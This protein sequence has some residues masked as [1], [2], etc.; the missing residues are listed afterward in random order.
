V[1]VCV[2]GSMSEVSLHEVFLF[3]CLAL[4]GIKLDPLPLD[5]Y[6]ACVLC[7]QGVDV[8]DDSCIAE[9]E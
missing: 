8:G 3:L 1:E 9:V 5:I 6:E 4:D 7:S 2:D